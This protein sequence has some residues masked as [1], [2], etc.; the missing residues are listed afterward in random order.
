VKIEKKGKFVKITDLTVPLT[1]NMLAIGMRIY[2]GSSP[3]FLR[4]ELLTF[5][6]DRIISSK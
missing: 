1:I 6:K 4:E 2:P 3:P 5:K